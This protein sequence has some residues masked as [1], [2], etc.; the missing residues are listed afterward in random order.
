M[1]QYKKSIILIV[2]NRPDKTR[3]TLAALR[4]VYL[5]EQ[6]NLIVIRQEGSAE[7]KQIIDEISWIDT[8]HYVTNYV[9]QTSVKYRINNNVRTGLELAFGNI[10]CKYVVVVED[11]ILLGYDFF[12]FCDLMHTRYAR[13]KHFRAIN[14]FSREP[15]QSSMLWS[16]GKFRYGIGKG[17]SLSRAAWQTLVAYWKP[18]V[19]QHFDYLIEEWTIGGFV[20]MP[21][22]SRSL[23][24]GWGEGSSHGPKDEFHEHWVAMRKSWVGSDAF[25]L[26]D[27]QCVERLPFS[28]RSDCLPYQ[29]NFNQLSRLYRLKVK[30]LV[31]RVLGR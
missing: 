16:Y 7:V 22:C 23:D 13:D 20:L 6:F 5:I 14:A 24:I 15:Y 4:K 9:S 26:E 19:D 12:H 30:N 2:F 10:E 3:E 1:S 31:K 8:T 28:W 17:W 29:N 27:Y 25:T 21:H 11:D 18:G